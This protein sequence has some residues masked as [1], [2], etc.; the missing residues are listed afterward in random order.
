M[1]AKNYSKT[2]KKPSDPVVVLVHGAGAGLDSGFLVAAKAGFEAR[3]L[4]V[5][6]VEFDYMIQARAAGKRRP[7][8]AVAGLVVEL[9]EVVE[10]LG[11]PV[12][13]VGKSMGGRIA[14]MLAASDGMPANVLAVSVLG[15]PF[16]PTGKPHQLRVQ[17]F[18]Q[19]Q[20]PLMIF[21]GSRDPFGRA[22]EI[23]PLFAA[24]SWPGTIELH[25]L[26]SGDHDFQPTRRSGKSRED[27][28]DEA[29]DATVTW[30]QQRLAERLGR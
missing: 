7:P 6:G 5:I 2:V 23:Q 9:R 19:I 11:K 20:V 1:T 4:T 21:Q 25:W 27:L 3:G 10:A 8:P 12:V 22:A 15:Y 14:S 26:E 16:H 30:M 18:E 24:S 28:L 13:I 29:L 17:H